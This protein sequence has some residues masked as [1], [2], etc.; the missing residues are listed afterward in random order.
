MKDT[1]HILHA[2]GETVEYARLYL[3]QQGDIIRLE[4]AERT[5]K[6]TSAL[7][8][9]VVLGILA[10][11]VL[12]ML[13]IAAGFWL[14]EAVGSAALAF[15]FVAI[16]YALLGGLLYFFRRQLVTHPALNFILRKFFEEEKEMPPI[17]EKS[18][19]ENHN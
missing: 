18:Y 14:T 19:L 12:V 17:V 7:I 1:N 15:L 4:A 6:V 10:L 3:E 9:A 16:G 2:A 13:S 5:A 8:T 11:L